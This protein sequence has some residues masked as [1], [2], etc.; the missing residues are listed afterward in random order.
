MAYVSDHAV[1]R[2]MERTGLVDVEAIQ[3][4]LTVHGIDV[5]A[6]FGCGTVIL[7]DGTRLKLVGSR[8]VTCLGKPVRKR[9]RRGRSG[10]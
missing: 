9:G 10:R 6:A 4:H 8:A 2:W 7:G 5:A 3:R 1:L